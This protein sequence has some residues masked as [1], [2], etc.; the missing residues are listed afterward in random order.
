[1]V[2]K[3]ERLEKKQFIWGVVTFLGIFVLK[4]LAYVKEND[5]SLI[6][7]DMGQIAIAAVLGGKDWSEVIAQT[8]YYGFGYN[9]IFSILFRF[10]D[11][12]YMIWLGVLIINGLGLGLCATGIYLIQEKIF[13]SKDYVLN[14]IIAIFICLG[15]AITWSTE[16][17][18]F[19]SVWVTVVL[20]W[21]TYN[22]EGRQKTILSALFAMWLC[23]ALT[24]HERN[25]TMV[26]TVVIMIVLYGL[27]YKATLVKLQAFIPSFVVFYALEQFIKKAETA[28]LWAEKI[29]DGTLKN[30]TVINGNQLWFL[31]DLLNGIQIMVAVVLS[32]LYT[33]INRTYG[34]G[35]FVIVFVFYVFIQMCKQKTFS[36]KFEEE[37]V[38]KTPEFFFGVFSVIATLIIIVGLAVQWGRGIANQN[39]YSYKGLVYFRYYSPFLMPSILAILSY[40]R[41][42]KV[43][44]ALPAIA[45]YFALYVMMRATLLEKMI[46]AELNSERDTKVLWAWVPWF[47][48][49]KDY[50]LAANA[51]LLVVILVVLLFTYFKKNIFIPMLAM[52]IVFR[53]SV[54]FEC[55]T[56]SI[57]CKEVDKTYELYS[58][59][60][61]KLP[62]EIYSTNYI[63]SL[64]Y[65]LGDKKVI[66][67]EMPA[68]EEGI[69]FS[70]EK[71]DG[72]EN[73]SL[74]KLETTEYLYVN[75][76]ELSDVIETYGIKRCRPLLEETESIF[77]ELGINHEW[78]IYVEPNMVDLTKELKE[79]GYTVTDRMETQTE[80]K[81]ILLFSSMNGFSAEQYLMQG[82]YIYELD[83]GYI[84]INDVDVFMALEEMYR[85]E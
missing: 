47:S 52:L 53:G 38:E 5:I 81:S 10:I 63:Y 48:D 27:I 41:K 13:G 75:G 17:G 57:V 32:N 78:E 28:Y 46:F 9:F 37:R 61:D 16:Y 62:D 35:A 79:L 59:I 66:T 70:K 68:E 15:T 45:G 85:A 69:Q 77:S 73:C 40:M 55:E 3:K 50:H 1:M 67:Q 2:T 31:D 49:M 29:S 12:P 8:S 20:F 25:T 58:A 74:F 4:M 7:D 80:G 39:F 64:Q 14:S 21:K 72:M 30:T 71:I 65:M 18:V 76:E 23:Y 42:Y 19:I 56:P 24:L 6:S 26:I 44:F 43:N 60:G 82:Y 11:N 22:A 34:L 51:S 33:L 54:L 83:S 84:G 36:I